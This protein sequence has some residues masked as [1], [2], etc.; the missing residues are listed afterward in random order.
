MQRSVRFELPQADNLVVPRP[1]Q[2][3]SLR[4]EHKTAPDIGVRLVPAGG[5][6]WG[7]AA[8]EEEE[9]EER[10]RT[11][12]EEAAKAAKDKAEADARAEKASAS[13]NDS[14][15]NWAERVASTPAGRVMQK[16]GGP[17]PSAK[18]KALSLRSPSSAVSESTP[19]ENTGSI[20]W[21][22][23]EEDDDTSPVRITQTA[24]SLCPTTHLSQMDKDFPKVGEEKPAEEPK[25]QKTLIERAAE[26]KAEEEA[27]ACEQWERAQAKLRE[28]EARAAETEKRQSEEKERKAQE[29]RDP[30]RPSVW[31]NPRRR[32]GSPSEAKRD[33]KP[34]KSSES[35]P[36]R[37][38][39]RAA[40]GNRD[41]LSPPKERRQRK[42]SPVFTVTKVLTNT[43]PRSPRRSTQALQLPPPPG[44]QAPLAPGEQAPLPPKMS[45]KRS[46][47]PTARPRPEAKGQLPKD[48][49]ERKLLLLK[50]AKRRAEQDAEA[51][52]RAEEEAE[53]AIRKEEE[54]EEAKLREA[55]EPKRATISLCNVKQRMDTGRHTKQ[56][57]EEESSR[58]GMKNAF[59]R[60]KDE[61]VQEHTPSTTEDTDTEA[62]ARLGI[63][64]SMSSPHASST[65]ANS[66]Q[67]N[68]DSE[69][70]DLEFTSVWQNTNST[71]PV[72]D[73]TCNAYSHGPPPPY[74]A[75]RLSELKRLMR[76]RQ[77]EKE[78]GLG[79]D[80]GNE[81]W[82][83]DEY[84]SSE[85][86]QNWGRNSEWQQGEE[87][88]SRKNSWHGRWKSYE[89]ESSKT[90]QY[91]GS[92]REY[93]DEEARIMKTESHYEKKNRSECKYGSKCTRLDCWFA[94]P[95]GWE[96][97][98][99]CRYGRKCTR[100]HCW[101]THPDGRDMDDEDEAWDDEN[102]AWDVGPRWKKREQNTADA[103]VA[104]GVTQR[105]DRDSESGSEEK[106]DSTAR[107]YT[108]S[109]VEEQDDSRAEPLPQPPS[110]SGIVSAM[111]S[112]FE[113]FSE[114]VDGDAKG[115]KVRSAVH[116][117]AVSESSDCFESCA[118]S[119]IF[120]S[121]NE[122]DDR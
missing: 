40:S 25:P 22:D 106:D 84:E 61:E 91:W 60:H 48:D 8:K 116:D 33:D 28:L 113:G 69:S 90:C 29:A 49:S 72:H 92:K 65:S 27:R 64:A 38:D 46:L 81:N 104:R 88:W 58:V 36:Q 54:N 67:I 53:E 120:S 32:I 68:V 115:G 15:L 17:S 108:E 4:S 43:A 41:V 117:D 44:E 51:R 98:S 85:T 20:R 105:E 66:K 13:T 56:S 111:S 70:S 71:P 5:R 75:P 87:N 34:Q 107:V 94:H 119:S 78:N 30:N 121:D 77:Q 73:F 80:N 100:R 101:W 2:L 109:G 76:K 110:E 3:G 89:Y 31:D 79:N 55:T 26:R 50:D 95:D 10:E 7:R 83:S 96:K 82:S 12:K 21:A 93:N 114:D 99:T 52:R 86:K 42:V 18:A 19:L 23:L 63:A 37:R 62:Q 97:T 16:L 6:G 102:Q 47:S 57:E 9:K 122:D 59:A 11:E 118:G 14:K 35:T 1:V 45:S 112:V 103:E 24:G 74:K 39:V